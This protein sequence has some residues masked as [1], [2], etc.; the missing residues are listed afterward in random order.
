[1]K[2][3][4][5]AWGIALSLGILQLSASNG[6]AAGNIGISTIENIEAQ[7][8]AKDSA[9]MA[10]IA[11]GIIRGTK[12]NNGVKVF[13]GI[14]YADTT[15][16]E[17]RF[18]PPQSVKP[19]SGIRNCTKFG[20]IAVQKEAELMGPWTSEYLDL[21]MTLDNDR[22]SEDC[23]NLNVWTTAQSGEKQPVIVYIHGGA[24]VS[25]SSENDIYSGKEI[26][27]KGVVYVSINYRVGIFGFLAY[28]DVAG[29]EV[30]G[31]FALLDQIAALKW[32]Q[33]NIRSF[34]GDPDNV[35]IMGQ[36]AGAINVQ[37]L[38]GSKAAAGLFKRAIALS[39]NSITTEYPVM[40]TLG[41]AE[42]EASQ[43]LKGRTLAEL[44][45]MTPEEIMELGYNP[46]TVIRDTSTGTLPLK[47]AFATNS[48][49]KVDMIWGG[50]AGDPYIFDSMIPIG[51]VFSPLDTLNSSSYKKKVQN[52]FG[53]NAPMA[54]QLY[55]E[56]EESLNAA[57]QI[58]QD[59]LI[60]SYDYA[61]QL[62]EKSDPHYRTY[63]YYYDHIL[64]DSEERQQKYGAFHTSDVSYWLDY[65]SSKAGRSWTKTD[66][67]LGEQMSGYIINFAK[68]GN[69]N[70]HDVK[71]KE[72]PLWKNVEA[73][74]DI[75]YLHIGDEIRY[76]TMPKEK[77][78]FWK[79][80]WR[81][82]PIK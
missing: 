81:I 75:S 61:G 26:A 2:K 42:K 63:I 14:P 36:S 48:W 13:K 39:F 54:L 1:M 52:R 25:G 3:K 24:N 50:V 66:Y 56:E 21:G 77:A 31:N 60:A 55:P 74:S 80:I 17:N 51:D 49:N 30:T 79:K 5:L 22:M 20:A 57:K 68:N 6:D 62:K 28:K 53:I 71:L 12:E 34:G 11:S 64:P 73:G 44:R 47:E 8:Y 72:L 69:P 23:L 45:K 27:S 32:V 37:H 41:E 67:K 59:A 10:Q 38:I 7:D 29:E 15:A 43:A 82:V 4:Y 46:S 65:Y 76:E 9:P 58:N 40:K 19:W 35:T 16:G 70:G 18:Q 78:Q 33:K